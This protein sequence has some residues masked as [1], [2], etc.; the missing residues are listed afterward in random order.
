VGL[1]LTLY[2]ADFKRLRALPVEQR[3]PALEDAVMPGDDWDLDALAARGWVWPP[4]V[5]GDPSWCAEYRFLNT[6][7]R[8]RNHSEV[9][10]G[11]DDMRPHVDRSLRDVVDVVLDHLIWYEN[12]DNG[13]GLT[14]GGLFPPAPDVY[15]ARVLI[16]CPPSAFAGKSAA[17]LLAQPRLEELREPFRLECEGWAGRPESFDAFTALLREWGEVIEET[18][19]RGW[20]LVGLPE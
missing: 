1:N 8:Y 9:G 14:G 15:C 11:W 4:Q 20:G 2:M 10:D 17:W 6:T 12:W 7:G 19:Y 3:I 5:P 13:P 18:A 16:V